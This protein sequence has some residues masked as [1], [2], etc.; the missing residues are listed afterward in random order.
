MTTTTERAVRRSPGETL[1]D[2]A[3][4]PVKLVQAA[5][6]TRV[7]LLAAVLRDLFE[8]LRIRASPLRSDLTVKSG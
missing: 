6:K 7:S 3:I 4:A 2:E 5:A 1:A 8:A